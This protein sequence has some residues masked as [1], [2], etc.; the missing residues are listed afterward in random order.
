[1]KMLLLEDDEKVARAIARIVTLLGHEL[2]HVSNVR[3]AREAMQSGD[4]SLVV[5]DLGLEAGESGLEFMSWV[6]EHHPTVRRVLT[7]GAAQPRGFVS[8]PPL[9][10]FLTKPFGRKELTELLG[11]PS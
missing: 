3:D 7:S 6:G 8:V 10:L 5:A 1:M 4:V 9:Q 11:S 2:V